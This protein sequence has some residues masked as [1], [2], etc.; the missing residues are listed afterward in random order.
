[1]D[2]PIL[3]VAVAGP[4]Q[5]CLD[6][7]S[8]TE[9]KNLIPGL[10]L[11]VPMR[12]K[13]TIGILTEIT[14]HSELTVD[15]IKPIHSILEDTPVISPS[16]FRLAY[17]AANYYHYPLG[18]V[19]LTTLP[20]K[21]RQATTLHAYEQKLLKNIQPPVTAPLIAEPQ[22]ILNE[23]QA[24]AVKEVIASFNS[25]Q[26]FLLF[27]ITGSGKTEVYL[28]IIE[29]ALKQNKQA[30]VLVP[31]IGLTPQTIM[32]FQQRFT[33]EITVIHSN[34]TDNERLKAWFL[35]R[36]NI[37]K[38]VIGTRSAIFTPMPNLGVII[39]DE[40]HDL[41]F[42]QQE[43]LRYFAR[44]LAVM[45]ARYEKIP[46][47]LG[48][49]T[50]SFE[51]LQNVITNRFRLLK[52]PE[53][54]G[55]SCLPTYKVVDLRNQPLK[56]GLSQELLR[57]ISEHLAAGNQVLLFL[58]RRGYAPC[59]LCHKCGYVAKCSRCDAK[60]TYH[61]S[62]MRLCCH[63]CGE[64]TKVLDN[65]P[66]CQ[67]SK[68]AAVGIGTQKLEL[69]LTKLFPN[70]N[71]VR[72]D[73]D[74]TRRKHAMQD[75]LNLI[76][77]GGGQILIGT[78]MLAKGHHFPN[79]S[80]VAI[81]D[82]DSGLMS[83]DFRA[84]ERL[85]Q[86]ITQVAGRAGRAAIKGTVII[87]THYP[88]HPLLVKLLREG[89][90]AFA[91]ASLQERKLAVLPPF[92]FHALFRAESSMQSL[93]MEFLQEIKQIIASSSVLNILGPMPALMEKRAGRFRAQLCLQA[94]S[95]TILHQVLDSLMPKIYTL[96]M[97]RKVRWS[98]DVDPQEMF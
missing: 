24:Q 39:I 19:L 36:D 41:S 75:L 18:E 11:L 8:P 58:N 63:H 56:E 67:N 87:E 15:K 40:E 95:R 71:I 94:S 29:E 33:I 81:L 44:D 22:P 10:R 55:G 90:G 92:C 80:L 93:P 97:S 4:I 96:K 76:Q 3:K 43:G 49:A 47:V 7:K 59:L 1:M 17:F 85:A 28:R 65:C 66:T 37:A 83:G 62:P 91:K 51:S 61:K 20:T 42:K 74:N 53:R 6:Y 46:L 2:T 68:L 78:Q 38:I 32:R 25:F 45:R 26:P 54:A 64:I 34:L 88:E 23:C 79:V 9:T 27:G 14:N 69:I 50:P 70:Y 89:Y 31:E 16:L 82:V 52:L 5:N 60:M 84:P 48:S 98:L 21:L 57:T 35:A 72:I 12:K 30:L 73:K 77:T 86:V 13:N